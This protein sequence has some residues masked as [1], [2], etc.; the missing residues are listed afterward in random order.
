M[1]TCRFASDPGVAAVL[2]NHLL[3]R[4]GHS[5]DKRFPVSQTF[6]CA[7][8]PLR[9]TATIPRNG[10]T[11]TCPVDRSLVGA[12]YGPLLHLIEHR[13]EAL[14]GLEGLPNL[15]AGDER[16]ERILHDR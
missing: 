14:P 5:R 10:S 7:T 12:G 9:G 6:V 15:L 4:R 2:V 8:G 11:V 3:L 16:I 1:Q 13:R